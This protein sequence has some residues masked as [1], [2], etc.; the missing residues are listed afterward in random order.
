ME[1][2]NNN[3]K[4]T[5]LMN[6]ISVMYVESIGTLTMQKKMENYNKASIMIEEAEKLI[7]TLQKEITDLP[8]NK[9]TKIKMSRIINELVKFLEAP[10]LKFSEVLSIVQ[11]LRTICNSLPTSVHVSNNLEQ[12]IVYEEN[13]VEIDN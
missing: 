6:E 5:D 3:K 1:T 8:Q 4:L 13:D 7:D 9:I 12:E 11:E 10:Q 2:S